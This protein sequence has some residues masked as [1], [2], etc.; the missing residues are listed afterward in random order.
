MPRDILLVSRRAPTLGDLVATSRSIDPSLFPVR[1]SDGAVVR[2]VG[3]ALAPVLSIQYS[4]V[5]H[6][7]DE[8]ERLAPEAAG[9][10]SVPASWT[11][12]WAPWGTEGDVGIHVARALAERIG[13]VCLVE[14]GTR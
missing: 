6:T 13:G 5:V 8:L 2:L 7:A 11:E 14:D 9:S 3:P 12:G 10:V 1:A 4:L